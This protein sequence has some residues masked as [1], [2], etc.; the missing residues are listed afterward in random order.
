MA[1]QLSIYPQTNPNG[2]YTYNSNAINQELVI[3]PVFWL[4]G[5]MGI[6]TLSAANSNDAM[7]ASLGLPDYHW[8]AWYSSGTTAPTFTA[9]NGGTSH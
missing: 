5:F 9:Y 2:Q 4:S 3:D 1:L 6:N 7:I 8:K